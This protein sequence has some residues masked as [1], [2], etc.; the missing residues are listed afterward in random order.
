MESRGERIWNMVVQV[1]LPGF[2]ILGF[3]LT[4]IK[5]PQY[6]LISG[7]VSEIFWAYASY[8]AWK[9]GQWGIA[10]TTVIVTIIFIYG[11]LNYWF[12]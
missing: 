8:R 1:C 7:L 6:G 9:E 3:L 11:I 2:T 12:F 5:L 4:S 10:V